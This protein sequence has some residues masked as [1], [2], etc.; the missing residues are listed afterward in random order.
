M[1]KG[2]SNLSKSSYIVVQAHIF[3]ENLINE[4]INKTNNIPVKYD[5]LITTTSFNKSKIIEEYIKN[6]SNSYKYEIKIV[7]NKGRDV[8]PLLEQLKNINDFFHFFN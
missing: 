2:F 7:E 1:G 8:L 5:L 6:Y 4:I 3:Y